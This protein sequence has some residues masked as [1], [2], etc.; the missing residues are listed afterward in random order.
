MVEG[1]LYEGP[2]YV[3]GSWPSVP[4]GALPVTGGGWELQAMVEGLLYEGSGYERS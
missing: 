1:L 2:G 3:P 4:P